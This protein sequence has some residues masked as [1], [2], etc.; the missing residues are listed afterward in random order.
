M[1]SITI[2]TDWVV[3]EILADTM[4]L[5]AYYGQTATVFCT[6]EYSPDLIGRHETALHPNYFDRSLSEEDHVKRMLDLYPEAIGIRGHG[7]YFNGR[8]MTDIYPRH[9][10]KYSSDYMMPYMEGIRPFRLVELWEM[11]I[12]F[13]D[14]TWLRLKNTKQAAAPLAEGNFTVENLYVF[15]FHPIHIYLNTPSVDYYG[16]IKAYYHDYQYLKTRRQTGAT[17]AR[18]MLLS[19]LE[20]MKSLKIQSKP[21]GEILK[22]VAGRGC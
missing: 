18:D 11:P 6:S 19:L 1:V 10:I 21:L 4:G 3:P 12:Y 16:G 14:M 17:G 20:R 15:C 8:L 13:S 7:L 2:D 22:T 9:G 5:L